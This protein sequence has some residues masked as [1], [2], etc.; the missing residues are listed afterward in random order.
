MKGWPKTIKDCPRSIQS[1][2]YFRDEIT[3][4]DNILYKGTRLIIPQSDRSSTLRSLA[5]GTLCHG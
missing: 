5:H 3:A 2:W 1:Y 4:E